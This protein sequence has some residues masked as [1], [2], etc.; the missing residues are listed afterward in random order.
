MNSR[1]KHKIMIH[2]GVPCAKA[3]TRFVRLLTAMV[4]ALNKVAGAK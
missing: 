1:T 4:C 2:V 3:L